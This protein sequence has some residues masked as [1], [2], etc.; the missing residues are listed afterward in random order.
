MFLCIIRTPT[1]DKI[2]EGKKCD[3]TQDFT[4]MEIFCNPCFN[5]IIL[6]PGIISHTLLSI[7]YILIH[8]NNKTVYKTLRGG[9]VNKLSDSTNS[10]SEP[11]NHSLPPHTNRTYPNS[12][13]A[14][15]SREEKKQMRGKRRSWW[16]T[17]TLTGMMLG[18]Q[19]WLIK[20]LMF[21]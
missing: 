16:S 18:S 5:H 10:T 20:R 2:L 7:W 15:I 1:F 4:V 14:L 11:D 9:S 3:Y 13:S 6:S 8:I 21:P 19:R 12:S 17:N